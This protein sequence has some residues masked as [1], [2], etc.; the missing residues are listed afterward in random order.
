[1]SGGPVEAVRGVECRRDLI[2][3]RQDAR[4]GQPALFEKAIEVDTLDELGVEEVPPVDHAAGVH[5]HD[6]GVPEPG[7]SL[8]LALEPR[9]RLGV[10][11]QPR[12]QPLEGDKAVQVGVLRLPHLAHPAT[13]EQA[14][15]AVVAEYLPHPAAPVG[16][17]G[18]SP[19]IVS[20]HHLIEWRAAERD[21]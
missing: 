4:D 12:L 18:S 5:P 11:L 6:V 8:R 7:G 1:L 3:D 17:I 21:R 14:L 20:S 19:L 10:D 9:Q 13:S 2:D 16:S 15:E